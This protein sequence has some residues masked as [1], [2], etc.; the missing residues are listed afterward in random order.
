MSR[1]G[2]DE[3]V[4]RNEFRKEKDGRMKEEDQPDGCYR[5]S[6]LVLIKH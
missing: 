3:P 2:P 1:V 4:R 6:G 5:P